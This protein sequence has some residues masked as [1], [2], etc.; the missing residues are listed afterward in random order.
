MKYVQLKR[1][2]TCGGH[3][4]AIKLPLEVNFRPAGSFKEL[5]EPQNFLSDPLFL[6]LWFQDTQ[7]CVFWTV[8]QNT[9]TLHAFAEWVTHMTDCVW[10]AKWAEDA[11][12]AS[13]SERQQHVALAEELSFLHSEW[14]HWSNVFAR[15]CV[16]ICVWMRPLPFLLRVSQIHLNT[17]LSLRMRAAACSDNDRQG[18]V[19]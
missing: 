11:T 8:T 4:S 12:T 15:V 14:Y 19:F 7:D 10:S 6:L 17:K 5:T 2:V 13:C 3:S 18:V 1:C 9:H 16:C